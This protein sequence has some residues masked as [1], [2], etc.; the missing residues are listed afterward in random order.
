MDGSCFPSPAP[1]S[2]AP[3]SD[4]LVLYCRERSTWVVGVWTRSGWISRAERLRLRPSHWLP[5]APNVSEVHEPS[6]A[7]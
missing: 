4:P 2:L 5:L 7:A 3:H 6:T 1:I